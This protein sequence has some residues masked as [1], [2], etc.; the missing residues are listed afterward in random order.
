MHL[1]CSFEPNNSVKVGSLYL[2]MQV[3]YNALHCTSLYVH[4]YSTDVCTCVCHE[5]VLSTFRESCVW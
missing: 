5:R 2:T 4:M 3:H 1:E